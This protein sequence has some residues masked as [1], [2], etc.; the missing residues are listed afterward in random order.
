LVA[1][2]QKKEIIQ[3]ACMALYRIGNGITV[4]DVIDFHPDLRAALAALYRDEEER[5]VDRIL[6]L[7]K[8]ASDAETDAEVVEKK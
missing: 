7:R 6:E 4:E 1:N 8:E 2:A 5:S 3:A